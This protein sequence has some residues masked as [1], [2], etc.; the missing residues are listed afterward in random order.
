MSRSS[1]TN[2]DGGFCLV[3]PNIS[4]F[5]GLL[6]HLRATNEKSG[7]FIMSRDSITYQSTGFGEK[8][9]NDIVLDI[10]T[11]P[12]KYSHDDEELAIGIDIFDFKNQINTYE[13]SCQLEIKKVDKDNYLEIR[14]LTNSSMSDSGCRSKLK[15]KNIDN[16]I[17]EVP[18]YDRS[19]ICAVTTNHLAKN[20]SN[21]CTGSKNP[22]I[23]VYCSDTGIIFESRHNSDTNI[24]TYRIGEVDE[25][26]ADMYS[27]NH[28]IVKALGKLSGINKEKLTKIFYR[29][30]EPLRLT[31]PISDDNGTL[32]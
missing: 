19:P 16:D 8:L 30:G 25:R 23:Y 29:K 14:P 22:T 5:K 9:L 7:N 31:V 10:S 28:H 26:T 18:E 6:D 4:H 15:L 12:Y 27:I 20:L 21:L 1:I 13:K 24:G 2:Y 3:F 11:F 17:N 32:N